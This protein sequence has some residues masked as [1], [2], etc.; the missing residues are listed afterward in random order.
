MTV[1]Q[2]LTMIAPVKARTL[3]HELLGHDGPHEAAVD[4]WLGRAGAPAYRERLRTAAVHA[5]AWWADEPPDGPTLVEELYALGRV[6]DVLLLDPRFPCYL[7]LF[8][9]LGMTPF[10]GVAPFDPFLHEIAEVEQ[11]EDPRAPIEVLEVRHP[12]LMLG[13]LLF[14]RAAVRIRA[15]SAHA[16]RGVADRFPLYW[17][18]RRADRTTHDLSHGWGSNS[19]W[20]TDF[21]L[22]YRTPEGDHLNVAEDGSV[23]GRPELGHYKDLAPEER[24]LTPAERRELLRNRCLLR[25]PRATADLAASPG[26]EDDLFP[27]AWRLPAG[28]A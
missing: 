23:D 4:H 15:G 9:A 1:R 26:W 11:A 12:G 19:Q 2:N 17:T 3:Y 5:T 18:F 22:D 13:E 14:A 21:R 7:P 16:E 10:D 25:T 20:R 27:F 28:E 6:A 8:T 24:L